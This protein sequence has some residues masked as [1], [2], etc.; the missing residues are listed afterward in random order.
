MLGKVENVKLIP[1]VPY[2]ELLT[3]LKHCEFVISDSG[4]IQE[5]APSFGKHCIVLR[6]VTERM[7][8][9]NLGMSELVGTDVDK[10]LNAVKQTIDGKIKHDLCKNPYGDGHASERILDIIINQ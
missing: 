7:E 8:S 3:L 9:V 1:P 5:E 6:E 4:G 2:L 10:I